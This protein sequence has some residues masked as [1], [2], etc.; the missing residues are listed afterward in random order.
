MKTSPE[1]VELDVLALQLIH[2]A[3]FNP[4]T[5]PSGEGNQTCTQV[6][7]QGHCSQTCVQ[8]LL[9]DWQRLKGQQ[10]K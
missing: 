8:G 6:F 3:A 5:T 7:A 9:K 2:G 10:K 1:I 4:D